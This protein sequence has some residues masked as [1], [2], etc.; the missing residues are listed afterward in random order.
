VCRL[1]FCGDALLI[2]WRT[3]AS[4]FVVTV[5]AALA[6]LAGA[7]PTTR[8]TNANPTSDTDLREHPTGGKTPIE[9]SLGMYIT[10]LVAVDETRESFEVGGYLSAQWRDTRLALPPDAASSGSKD[11]RAAR[12]FR[13]DQLWTPPIEAANS[14]T[15][16]TNAY[17]MEVDA[18]G[19]V[20]Y[21]ER[22]DAVLSNVYSLRKFPFDTQVLRFEF[23]P[24][25]SPE[26]VIT[27]APRALPLTGISSG[28]N[29]ELASWRTG[30]LHY[31]ADEVP[32]RGMIPA[33]REALFELVVSRRPAFYLWKIFLP[34]VMITLIPSVVFWID[35]KEFDWLLKIPMTMLL[36]TVA[37]EL[38]ITRDLPKAGYV[39]FLDAVFVTGFV[40]CFLCIVE[41]AIVYLIQKRGSPQRAAKIHSAGRLLYPL[42]YLGLIFLLA[43]I[44]LI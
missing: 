44:F 21:I 6:S 30:E 20:T 28:R 2:K 31:T 9:V 10:D 1:N 19:L 29:T 13:T 41:I 14:I 11:S 23:Q 12:I 27:F 33:T 25:L 38:A 24:F 18:A 16:K 43:L 3:T 42:S 5:C 34:L 35:A 36:S 40:F 37:F 4:V 26:S 7:H 17:S 22:F 8:A 15:H 32:A 39:T